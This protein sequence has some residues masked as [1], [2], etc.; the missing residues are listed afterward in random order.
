MRRHV[1][2]NAA[3]YWALLF[4]RPRKG[5]RARNLLPHMSGGWSLLGPFLRSPPPPSSSFMAIRPALVVLCSLVVTMWCEVVGVSIQ[6]RGSN[7]R[8]CRSQGRSRSWWPQVEVVV[9]EEYLWPTLNHVELVAF[10]MI[11]SQIITHS[12]I[13]RDTK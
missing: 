3:S 13:P 2:F 1:G 7:R 9:V 11:A 8:W 6:A 5:R 4:A 12:S 10:G